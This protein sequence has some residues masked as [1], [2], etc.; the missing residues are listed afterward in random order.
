MVE[1][2]GVRARLHALSD[3]ELID[4]LAWR[5]EGQWE[6]EVF[7]IAEEVLR[8]RGTAVEEAVAAARAAGGPAPDPESPATLVTVARYF[9]PVEAQLCRAHLEQAGLSPIIVDENVA[10]VHFLLGVFAGGIRVQVPADQEAVALEVL[11]QEAPPEM[12]EQCP[13]CGSSEVTHVVR[14][15]RI[16]SLSS[17]LIFGVPIGLNDHRT[18]CAACGYSSDK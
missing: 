3:P 17:G 13:A 7:G 10:A 2:E 16:G 11:S 5:D 15:D 14:P 9:T 8:G 4:I 18:S 6:P 1:R 12:P